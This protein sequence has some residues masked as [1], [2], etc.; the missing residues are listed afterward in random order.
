[1]NEYTARLTGS[2]GEIPNQQTTI[3]VGASDPIFEQQQSSGSQ[4]I[5]IVDVSDDSVRISK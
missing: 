4:T 1:V 3:T 5:Q 2:R